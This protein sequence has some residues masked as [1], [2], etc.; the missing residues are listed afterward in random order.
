MRE[1]ERERRRRYQGQANA[2][3]AQNRLPDKHVRR[4]PTMPNE[5]Y[6]RRRN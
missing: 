4:T 6:E 5:A 3:L 2:S 1:R